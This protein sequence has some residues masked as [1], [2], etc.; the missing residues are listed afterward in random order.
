MAQEIKKAQAR[1]EI[2]SGACSIVYQGMRRWIFRKAD[3]RSQRTG[4]TSSRLSS[5][6]CDAVIED[7]GDELSKGLEAIRAC[8]L[9]RKRNVQA[10]GGL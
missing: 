10:R 3:A 2:L 9:F 4:P 1:H 8:G 7:E 5:N 6:L